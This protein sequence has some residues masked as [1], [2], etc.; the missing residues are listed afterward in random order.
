MIRYGFSKCIFLTIKYEKMIVKFVAIALALSVCVNNRK[1]NID[2]F[3]W[4]QT[5]NLVIVHLSKVTCNSSLYLI[6]IGTGLY[7]T[8]ISYP[9]KKV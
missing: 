7:F 1:S 8:E 5:E 2:F 6:V 4:R 9:A 3:G